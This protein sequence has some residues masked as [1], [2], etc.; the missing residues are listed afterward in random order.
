MYVEIDECAEDTDGCDQYCTNLNGSYVC[1]CNR[2]Y[3][4]ASDGHNCE[5]IVSP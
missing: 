2:G 4:L 1:S 5:G 3:H